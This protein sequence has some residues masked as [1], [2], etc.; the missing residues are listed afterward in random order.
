MHAAC[1][2]CT[3]S[4]GRPGSRVFL[5]PVS[6]TC[7]VG[8]RPVFGRF[9]I[10]PVVRSRSSKIKTSR[11]P[12]AELVLSTSWRFVVS[13]AFLSP[14]NQRSMSRSVRLVSQQLFVNRP[15]PSALG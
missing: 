11:E 13:W 8:G 1:C 2:V 5:W 15:T 14:G 12:F 4:I 3:A 6:H 9:F 7:L 10:G